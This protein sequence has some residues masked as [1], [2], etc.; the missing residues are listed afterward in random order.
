M[1]HLGGIRERHAV[2]S[3]TI[4]YRISP[5]VWKSGFRH[6][7]LLNGCALLITGAIVVLIW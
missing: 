6:V 4:M 2:E 1:L 5:D 3:E 7:C